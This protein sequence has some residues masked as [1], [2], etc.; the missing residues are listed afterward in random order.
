RQQHRQPVRTLCAGG[1]Q[2]LRRVQ[3]LVLP[4]LQRSPVHEHVLA[5]GDAGPRGRAGQQRL[6]QSVF[7]QPVWYGWSLWARHTGLLVHRLDH[8]SVAVA[9]Q[10]QRE[11]ARS[12]AP[13]SS[14]RGWEPPTL[15][16]ALPQLVWTQEDDPLAI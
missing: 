8:H 3:R 14:A 10:T 9:R 5:G 2:R 12:S 13:S 6:L 16:D 15:V 7:Q 11:G 1:F 4:V